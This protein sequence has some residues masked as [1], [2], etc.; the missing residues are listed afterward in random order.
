[1]HVQVHVLVKMCTQIST[2]FQC[3]VY[4]VHVYSTEDSQEF[5]SAGET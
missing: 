3:L 2:K 5:K 4:K 1:M